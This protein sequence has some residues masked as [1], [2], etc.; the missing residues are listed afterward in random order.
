MQ[1]VI[2]DIRIYESDKENI[3]GNSMP[4]DTGNIIKATPNMTFIAQRIARKLNEFKCSFG[5]FDHIYINLTA[6]LEE[7]KMLFSSRKTLEW[8]QYIDVGINP[9]RF[10]ALKDE[11]KEKYIQDLIFEVL[12]FIAKDEL[13]IHIDKTKQL[14]EKY[15]H[16]LKI[17][18][19]TKETKSYKIEIYYQICPNLEHSLGILEYGDKKSGFKGSVDF[20][21]HFYDDIYPLIDTVS[22]KQDDVIMK[23]K[24]SF[25]AQMYNERYKVPLVFN[26]SSFVS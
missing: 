22:V 8:M 19:K 18:Y 16:E 4:H 1:R 14:I 15:K 10:N 26:L 6:I 2:K 20:Y 7:D 23:P 13:K 12:Y 11:E 25:R 5:E 9:S 21:L 3:A 24:K 17:H